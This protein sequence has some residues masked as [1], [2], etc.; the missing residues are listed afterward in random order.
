MVG[1]I[2]LKPRDI[3][4]DSTMKVITAILALAG[5]VL[6]QNLAGQPPCAVGCPCASSDR[7]PGQPKRANSSL[8]HQ[9]ACLVS[10]ISAAGCA[11]S[12]L[13]CQCGPTMS[14]IAASAAPCILASCAVPEAVQAET[15]G[16]AVCS[17]YLVKLTATSRPPPAPTAAGGALPNRWMMAH[18][19]T[20][21]PVS[22]TAA[23]CESSETSLLP[24]SVVTESP[25]VATAGAAAAATAAIAGA[26]ALL[27][28]LGAI[29]AL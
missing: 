9:T 24:T 19:A 16:S 13:G 4:T 15:A 26:G 29:A 3:E 23:V 6:A 8:P 17:S 28:A 20:S 5:A 1:I 27:V 2:N 25:S 22:T 10:A 21:T 18:A 7:T 12:D 11:A 14:V